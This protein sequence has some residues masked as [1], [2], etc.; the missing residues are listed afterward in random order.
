[1]SFSTLFR[2]VNGHAADTIAFEVPESERPTL[3]AAA[4]PLRGTVAK[5]RTMRR[6]GDRIPSVPG[7]PA[8]SR[9]G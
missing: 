1:M 9:P 5:P 6:T 4:P 8:T 7:S 3:F 2:D